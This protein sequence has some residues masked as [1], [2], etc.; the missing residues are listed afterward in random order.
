MPKYTTTDL[1]NLALLGSAG[2]GKTTLVE[3]MLHTAGV[4]GRA[5]RVE[6]KQTVSDFD[7]LEKE[8][9]HSLNSA[10]VHFDHEGAHVNL[11]DTPG[12]PDFLGMSISTL[13]AVET[14]M[15]MID[16]HAGVENVT[17][18][19]MKRAEERNLP[20][21]LVVNKIDNA[22]DLKGLL[23]SIQEVFGSKCQPLN[24]PAENATKVVDCF[25]EVSGESDFGDIG[26]FHTGIIEQVVEVD[27]ELMAEY[28]E[29]GEIK[30]ERLHEPF[31]RALREQHLVPICFCSARE[32][33]GVKELMT[34]IVKLCP[35]PT[36]GNPRPFEYTDEAGELHAFYGKAD[37]TLPTV[38]HVFKVASDPFIGKLAVFRVHQGHIGSDFSPSIGDMKKSVRIAHVFKLM[39]KD[40]KEIDT[41]IAG[42]IGAVAK[43]D[44]LHYDSVMHDGTISDNL[45]LKPLIL[46]K[47]MFGQAVEGTSKGAETKLGE[48]IRKMTAEDPTLTFERVAATG[49]SVLRGLGEQHLRL[50]LQMLKDRYG[51]EVETHPP[52]V[53]YKETITAPAEGHHR[54]KK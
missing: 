10:L 46:P 34:N 32:N 39:G 20:T 9:G 31:E 37:S 23:D 25:R 41:I 19:M 38:A 45:H 17:R 42:D 13:P 24:L 5:G 30:P 11:I 53:A 14:A 22:L 52:K 2:A 8:H 50:K 35:N 3:A 16:A 21:V 7:E 43:I 29:K 49:E 1:R 44:E 47:P 27:E 54:H 33:I 48:A 12:S 36:E 51:V 6:D 28:L 26:A 15:I 18:R 4:I 40:H